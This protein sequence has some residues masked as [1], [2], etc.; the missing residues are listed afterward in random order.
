[1]FNRQKRTVTFIRPTRPKFF[2]FWAFT[3]SGAV[4]YSWDEVKVRTY[5]LIVSNAGKSF[6]ESYWM[7]LFWGELDGRGQRIV[8]DCVPIGYEGYFE[9]ERLFQVWEHIRRYM[10]EGGPPIQPGEHL[11]KPANNRK[12]MPFPPEVIAAAGG[13]ALDEAAVKALAGID[14]ARARN[15]A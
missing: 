7:V 8:K 5:K 12:P 11:R 1:M 10:E 4:T 3:E 9:D 6:H 14:R 15:E 2:K 13:Q